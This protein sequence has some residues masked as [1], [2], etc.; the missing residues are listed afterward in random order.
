MALSF[1]LSLSNAQVDLDRNLIAC[2]D[3]KGDANDLKG[4]GHDGIVYGAILTQDRYGNVNNAYDFNGSNNYIN[5]R[6]DF[7]FPERTVN[8]WFS[9]DV[10]IQGSSKIIYDSDHPELNYGF[11]KIRVIENSNYRI[12]GLR[13]G[14]KNGHGKDKN[15]NNPLYKVV[16]LSAGENSVTHEELISENQWFMATICYSTSSNQVKYYVNGN[17]VYTGSAFTQTSV[18]GNTT[19]NLGK[20]RGYDR[21]FDGKIDDLRIYNRTLSAAEITALYNGASCSGA[22]AIEKIEPGTNH[23]KVYPNPITNTAKI[24]IPAINELSLLTFTLYNSQGQEVRNDYIKLA[25]SNAF[26]FDRKGL[27]SGLYFYCVK[28]KK[29]LIG[30]G[31]I[32]LQ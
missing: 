32:V 15:I 17:L 9:A 4:N 29:T 11:T 25:K 18:D 1:I 16:R 26:I 8:V 13:S 28:D 7:D 5:L 19:V 30:T 6:S 22:L 12:A 21:Y 3:F 2:Y 23:L 27:S 31:K 10:I 24:Q 20:S 14:E